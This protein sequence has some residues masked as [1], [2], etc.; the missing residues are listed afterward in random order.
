MFLEMMYIRNEFLLF[1]VFLIFRTFVFKIQIKT[2]E[3]NGTLK[4][5]PLKFLKY[6]SHDINATH[7]L[8]GHLLIFRPYKE[9]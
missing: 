3:S 7:F 4:Y 8:G 6:Y 9:T 1:I 2:Y 5:L